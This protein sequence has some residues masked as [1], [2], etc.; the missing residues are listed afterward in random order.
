MTVFATCEGCGE[1]AKCVQTAAGLLCEE[2]ERDMQD[3]LPL[4][5]P[6]DA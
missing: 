6:E 2:C 3:G 1:G 4:E 5:V